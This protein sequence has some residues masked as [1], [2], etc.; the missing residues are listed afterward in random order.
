MKSPKNVSPIQSLKQT[1]AN[2]FFCKEPNSNCLG[3]ASHVVYVRATTICC[4]SIE[5]V[6]ETIGWAKNCI[7]V[8]S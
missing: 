6:V 4:C 2:I 7:W 3:L 8:F 5:G 1:L